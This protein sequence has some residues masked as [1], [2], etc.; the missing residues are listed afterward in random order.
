M[1]AN[2]H[3]KLQRRL[4]STKRVQP[5]FLARCLPQSL[6]YLCSNLRLLSSN[7]RRMTKKESL[8]KQ[9][10]DSIKACHLPRMQRVNGTRLKE[11]EPEISLSVMIESREKCSNLNCPP[12]VLKQQLFLDPTLTCQQIS[13]SF[14]WSVNINIE[15]P[16]PYGVF[17]PFMPSEPGSAMRHI[18]KPKIREIEYWF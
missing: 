18:I 7:R 8:K 2:L 1:A 14:I 9:C 5:I 6:N 4:T 11:R 15:I 17:A 16:R 10:I 3:L 12:P 13:V